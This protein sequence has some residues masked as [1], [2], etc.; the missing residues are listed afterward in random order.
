MKEI[1]SAIEI[2]ASAD[3]VWQMLTD[4]ESYPLWHPTIERIGG[5]LQ[6]GAQIEFVGKLEGGKT[7]TFRP[8][9]L[10]VEPGRE[11][12]W[13]GKVLVRGLFDGE[14]RFEIESLAPGRVRLR[15]SE[16][17]RGVLVPLMLAMIGKATL[18]GFEAA[19]LALKARAEAPA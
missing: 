9:L 13:L 1:E 16:R 6:K 5:P 18:R 14:H 15:Q 7:M 11:L 8:T 4:F 17:F 12:R 19:N 10:V 3:R 2:E